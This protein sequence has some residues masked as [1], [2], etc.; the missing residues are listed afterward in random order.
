MNCC[1]SFQIHSFTI[2]KLMSFFIRKAAQDAFWP[3][4]LSTASVQLVLSNFGDITRHTNERWMAVHLLRSLTPMIFQQSL[5]DTL[6]IRTI[7]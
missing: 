2:S 7:D 4:V 5:A 3:P 1:N 6:Q